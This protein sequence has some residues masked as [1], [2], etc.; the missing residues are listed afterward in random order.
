MRL[1]LP[2]SRVVVTM[3]TG[4]PPM[5]LFTKLPLL[6]RNIAT[7]CHVA[8]RMMQWTIGVWDLGIGRTSAQQVLT[9]AY[10]AMG[11]DPE[12]HPTAN[13]WKMA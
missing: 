11:L 4:Y 13:L 1:G 8:E 9:P 3:H 5:N 6:A 12:L 2:E 10:S 7:L